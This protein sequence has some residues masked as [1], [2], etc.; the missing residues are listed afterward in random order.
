MKKI[1]LA[2]YYVL[3]VH[4]L[5]L[6][7]MTFQRILLLLMNLQHIQGVESKF[8]WTMSA[9][10]RGVWFDN[11]IACYISIV[12]LAILSVL[13]LCNKINR[14]VLTGFNVFY[15]ALYTIVFAIGTADIP[16]FDYFFKHLNTSIFN[17]KEEGATNAGMIL[18]ETSYYAYF[19]FFLLAILFFSFLVIRLSKRLL[20]KNRREIFGVDY[21]IYTPVCLVLIGLCIFGIRGRMGYNP[22]KTSQAYFCDNS[23]LNQLGINPTF[24]FLRD[25]IESSKKHYDVNG[26]I[27]EK[28][29]IANTRQYLGIDT[30]PQGLTPIV[31]EIIAEG[32]AKDMNVVIVLM[33]SMSADLL[34]VKQNGQEIT[35]FLN[36]LIAKSYYFE[37]FYS[38]GTHTNHG[39]LATL[40]GLPSI[41]DRNM[42]K[43]VDIPL[44]EGLPYVLQKQ[45]YRTMFFM[46]HE[47]QYDNINAFLLENGVEEIY[48]EENYPREKRVNSFGVADDY[49]FEYAAAKLQE[50][51]KEDKPFL[52]TLLT[53]SNHPPYIVPDRFRLVSDESQYQIVA[54][55]D[56]AIRQFMDRAKTEDWYNNTIFVFLGDHGKIVGSQVYEMP[57]SYNHIPLIIYSPAFTDAPKRF[58]Q[59]GG[60]V[61]VFPTLM[62]ILN[63][64]YTNNTFG[65]DL[66]NEDRKYMFFTSDDAIACIDSTYFYT[67]NFKTEM[68]GLFKYKNNG[69]ENLISPDR[70]IADSMS[71][72][73]TSILRTADFL[74]E[75][76]LTRSTPVK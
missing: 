22:I 6:L 42:M 54:F 41:M 33:E 65:V 2:L 8:S 1:K 73:T 67:R 55:A 26:L 69:T 61:D 9:L 12:P 59:F 32:E 16:Y 20:L 68:E 5:A 43:N 35:P 36:E 60:Q 64:S 66:F 75:N 21:L 58:A 37:N 18:Q 44:C 28:E 74:F 76:R 17:W 47:A 38:A 4:I 13:G 25:V 14:P 71:T 27:D 50:K 11:V 15:I 31:R 19:L 57:L 52:A 72:Y 70:A 30:I 7:F 40:Y 48:S 63:R 49:L 24:F 56:D 45:G 10:L 53:I 3:S 34:N 39:I 23:F 51:S 46:T 62:G 29:A